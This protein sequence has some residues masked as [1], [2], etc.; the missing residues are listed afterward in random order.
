MNYREKVKISKFLQ[1]AA[2]EKSGK[3][4]MIMEEKSVQQWKGQKKQGSFTTYSVDGRMLGSECVSEQTSRVSVQVKEKTRGVK[5]TGMILY[6]FL[7]MEEIKVTTSYKISYLFILK[8]RSKI[9]N[10]IPGCLIFPWPYLGE[11]R[12]SIVSA[13]SLPWTLW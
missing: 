7:V 2:V 9:A 4:K 6:I 12:C 3:V 13:E 8:R 11:V 10:W 5:G 1:E